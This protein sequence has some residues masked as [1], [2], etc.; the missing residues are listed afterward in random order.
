MQSRRLLLLR[1]AQAA[2]GPADVERPL[3]ERGARQAASAGAWLARSGL[4]PDRVVVSPALRAARSWELAGAPLLPRPTVVVD[5][6]I[7]DATVEE[8]LAVVRET[9]EDV[10]TLAVVGH[11]PSIGSLASILDD[12]ASSPA[13]R[14]DGERGFPAGGVAVFV[15]DAPFAAIAPGTATLG[16]FRA[17]QD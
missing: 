2:H 15:I 6:R 17:P 11:N 16:D 3:T 7:Y 9:P 4:V 5:P 12:G 8:L 14:R 10:R 13:A 1:H